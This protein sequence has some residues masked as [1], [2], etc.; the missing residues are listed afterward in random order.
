MKILS[1]GLNSGNYTV[2]YVGTDKPQP[3]GF[4]NNMSHI[5]DQ[6]LIVSG[7]PSW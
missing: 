1:L 6:I 5:F 2:T 7:F 3:Q 4:D